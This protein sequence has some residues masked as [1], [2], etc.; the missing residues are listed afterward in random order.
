MLTAKPFIDT[1]Q[2]LMIANCD[3]WVNHSI[4]DYLAAFD[5]TRYDGFLMTMRAV[6]P[7]GRM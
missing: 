2:P 3:Q 4:D 1:R 7:N 6:R 5:T